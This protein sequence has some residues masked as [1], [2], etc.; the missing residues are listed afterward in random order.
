[1]D[2]FALIWSS[3]HVKGSFNNAPKY[4]AKPSKAFL[5]KLRKWEKLKTK[6]S[7]NQIPQVVVLHTQNAILRN[8][9]E[10]FI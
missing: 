10:V 9:S 7:K 5:I 1:M 2:N 8:L 3:G 4:I 6:W